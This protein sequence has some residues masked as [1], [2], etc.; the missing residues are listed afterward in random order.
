MGAYREILTV[1][2]FTMFGAEDE[3][4]S[5]SITVLEDG[6]LIWIHPIMNITTH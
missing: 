6:S 5:I 3:I 2:G 4:Q 1:D